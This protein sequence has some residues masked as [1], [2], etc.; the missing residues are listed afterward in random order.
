MDETFPESPNAEQI[1]YWNERGGSRWLAL[2]DTLSRQMA[3]LAT[4]AIERADIGEGSRVL[5]V[6]CGCG[7]TTFELARRTGPSGAVTG[8]DVSLPLLTRAL[9]TTLRA[10]LGNVSFTL[11]DAQ[12]AALPQG[13]FDVLFSRFGVMFFSDPE[14]A[15]SNL[16]RALRPGATLTFLCWRSIQQ[17]PMMLVPAKAVAKLVPL[18][19][20]DPFAPGPFAFA[21]GARVKGILERAGFVDV[22]VRA[23]DRPLAVGPGTGLDDTAAFL[24]QI[25]PAAMALANAG[26]T[27]DLIEKAIA[28]VQEAIAPYDT[29]EGVMMPAAMWLVTGRARH[30]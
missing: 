3:P 15:F 30:E 29:P 6:G 8:V 5:D 11:A 16:L 18:P 2:H 24:T 1:R 4:L 10:G 25:G 9:Q 28:K 23:E 14:A 21:D 26:A 27:E 13:A 12:T 17:N 19:M 20:P 22:E 7:D